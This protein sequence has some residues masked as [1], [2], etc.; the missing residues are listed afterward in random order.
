MEPV[1]FVNRVRTY[2]DVLVKIDDEEKAK[3]KP[4]ALDLK[5]PAI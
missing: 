4:T 2:Y 1:I 5:A 3:N